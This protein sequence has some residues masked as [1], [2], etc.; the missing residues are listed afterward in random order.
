MSSEPFADSTG[1][2][3]GD[4]TLPDRPSV[5]RPDALSPAALADA[6]RYQPLRG[7]VGLAFVIP[8]TVVLSVGAGGALHSL[9][10][11]GPIIT[12]SLPIMAMIAFWWE[13]WPGSRLARAWSGLYD[14]AIAAAGGVLLTVLAELVIYGAPDVIGVFAPGPG[15]PGLYPISNAL[16]GGIFTIFLQLTLVCE[17]WP[18]DGMRRIPSGLASVVLC[19]ALGLIAWLI[20]V[21]SFGFDAENYGAWLTSIAA[22]QMLFYVG[23]RG[24]PFAR[25]GR[26]WL[27]LLLANIV[28]VACGWGSYL[29]AGHVLHWPGV[30]IT[31]TAGSV[32]GCVLLVAMLF[33]AWPAIRLDSAAVGRTV[34]VVIAVVITALLAWS[35]PML[36]HVLGV[37]AERE[38]SWTT[39]VMLNALST[40]VIMHVAVWQ[41]WPAAAI[42]LAE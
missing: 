22:W 13:D 12:F 30:Q 20:V 5:S 1:T 25:I 8:V 6:R 35:L 3:P 36:A 2:T 38:W 39:Q 31:A 9:I 37:P 4:G 10:L 23:V 28:V 26:R 34:V 24:W 42:Q 11:L 19:W 15:H 14:V 33:E 18:L 29:I 16:S 27:R 41:R 21:G 17:R 7:L 40:A 32:V